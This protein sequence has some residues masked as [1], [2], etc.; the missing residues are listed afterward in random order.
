M[1]ISNTYINK[2]RETRDKVFIFIFAFFVTIIY[3]FGLKSVNLTFGAEYYFD[4]SKNNIQTGELLEATL[5]LDT[6]GESINAIEGSTSF[7]RH[8]VLKQIRS[9]DSLVGFWVDLPK[10]EGDHVNFSGIVPGGYLG[11]LGSSWVGERP[12]RVFTL[13]FE[14]REEGDAW[15]QVDRDSIVLL[16]DGKGTEARVTIK[17]INIKVVKG[18]GTTSPNVVSWEDEKKPEPF[19]PIIELFPDGLYYLIFITRDKDSGVAY[20][21]IREGDGSFVVA[22]SPYLLEEQRLGLPILVRAVDKN[23]NKR[24][25]SLSPKRQLTWYES[26]KTRDILFSVGVIILFI[27][28]FRLQWRKKRK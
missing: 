13:V 17:D 24:L 2:K 23:G 4:I 8:L 11:E 25:A 19:Q 27:F 16:N 15:L 3:F 22:K 9:G 21:D 10:A 12:G 20:Y 18:E 6:E 26:I 5:M 14:A 1:I 7:S 28:V